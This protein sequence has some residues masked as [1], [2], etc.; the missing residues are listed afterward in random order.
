MRITKADWH[1]EHC[2][3]DCQRAYCP[4]HRLLYQ[5]CQDLRPVPSRAYCE[6]P[7]FT[8]IWE[9]AGQCPLCL[10]EAE[11]RAYLVA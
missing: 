5:V 2:D 7:P 10:R 1:H 11:R 8:T 3:G 9:G 4:D 6:E